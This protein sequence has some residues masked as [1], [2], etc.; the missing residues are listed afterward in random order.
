MNLSFS[1]NKWNNFTLADFFELAKQ[2]K[3]AGIEIHGIDD[4]IDKNVTDIYHK[5]IE[6]NISIACIDIVNDISTHTEDAFAEF[7]KCLDVCD[8]LR[9]PY[10]RIKASGEDNVDKFISA[11]LPKAEEAKKVLLVET[12][13]V[14]ADTAKLRELLVEYASDYLA[15]LWDLHYPYRVC[16]ETPEQT[17]KNLGAYVKHIHV[18]DSEG[19]DDHSLIGEG[20]MPIADFIHALRSVNYAGFMSIEWD[21]AWYDEIDDPDIIFP[22]FVS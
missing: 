11:A 20:N 13:G 8:K 21:P 1:T 17:I 22:H 18:K 6:Y 10:I 5:L 9:I 7:E 4:M 16:G 3:F 12:M 2:Y 19:T 15:A 14:Y